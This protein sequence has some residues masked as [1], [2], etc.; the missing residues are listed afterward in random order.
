MISKSLSTSVCFARL[1]EVCPDLAEFAQ[2]LYPLLVS[3]ADDFGRE[4]G[5]VLTVKYRIHPRSPR[6][7]QEFERAIHALHDVGLIVWYEAKGRRCYQVVKFDDHQTGLH[8]RTKSAFPAVPGNSG[9]FPESPGQ[10]KRTEEKRTEGKGT[11]QETSST[12][13]R[14]AEPAVISFPTVGKVPTWA[15]T[16]PQ[17]AEWGEQFPGIDVPGEARK[18]LAWVKANPTKRKT[19]SGMPRFLVSW[20]GRSVNS[21]RAAHLPRQ[22]P[23]YEHMHVWREECERLHGSRCGNPRFHAAKMAEEAETAVG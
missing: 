16:R 10:L 17:I 14:A 22:Q 20:L 21:G 5:D 18:A 3:H 1:F 6:S 7:E 9:N 11:E 12:P 13:L 19:A 23:A 8:K 15:L 2:S 4:Q